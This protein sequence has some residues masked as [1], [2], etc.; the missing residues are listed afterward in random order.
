MPS[1]NGVL[2]YIPNSYFNISNLTKDTNSKYLGLRIRKKC[3]EVSFG[4]SNMFLL[5]AY[6]EVS[7][8]TPR[9]ME[10]GRNTQPNTANFWEDDQYP[11]TSFMVYDLKCEMLPCTS[12][13]VKP[14]RSAAGLTR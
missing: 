1:Q 11:E 3:R 6:W 7:G 4:V 2:L 14:W 8:A 10:K 12:E 5:S 9:S 13:N